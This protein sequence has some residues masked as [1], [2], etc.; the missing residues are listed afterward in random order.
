M[1]FVV[2]STLL[3]SGNIGIEVIVRCPMSG[4][5]MNTGG[6]FIAKK[7]EDCQDC[8]ACRRMQ[9]M[10]DTC[11]YIGGTTRCTC[12]VKR[13]QQRLLNV[14]RESKQTVLRSASTTRTRVRYWLDYLKEQREEIERDGLD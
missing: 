3:L 12:E 13:A 7:C 4:Y 11:E 1:P 9:D 2:P 8:D 10:Y 14:K 6:I 5:A